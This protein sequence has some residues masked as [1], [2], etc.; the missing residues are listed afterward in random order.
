MPEPVRKIRLAILPVESDQFP[1]LA[2]GLNAALRGAHLKGIDD[3]FFSK[4]T[5][6]VVQL[7]IECVEQTY[8]CYTQVGRSMDAQRVLL[9]QVTPVPVSNK[10][11][12][13]VRVSLSLFDSDEGSQIRASRQTFGSE[14]EALPAIPKML[15]EVVGDLQAAQGGGPS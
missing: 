1:K 12:R 13:S 3:Y 8:E 15:Q 10:K 6:E 5:L 2:A 11:K 9:A 14:D 4:V 7:S